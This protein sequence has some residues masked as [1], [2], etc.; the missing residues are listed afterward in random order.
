MKTKA[1]TLLTVRKTLGTEIQNLHDLREKPAQ[2]W[3]RYP[4]E[5]LQPFSA[6]PQSLFHGEK[7]LDRNLHP[8]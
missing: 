8:E 7:M 4:A 2:L 3:T 6:D 5:S 1:T